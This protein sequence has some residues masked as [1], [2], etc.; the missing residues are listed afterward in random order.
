MMVSLVLSFAFLGTVTSKLEWAPQLETPY[1][2]F[3]NDFFNPDW[4]L[5]NDHE[6]VYRLSVPRNVYFGLICSGCF[7]PEYSSVELRMYSTRNSSYFIKKPPSGKYWEAGNNKCIMI[8]NIFYTLDS[9]DYLH[10]DLI[11]GSKKFSGVIELVISEFE[12][13]NGARGSL[14]RQQFDLTNQTVLDCKRESDQVT[15]RGT[16]MTVWWYENKELGIVPRSI[17]KSIRFLGGVPIAIGEKIGCSTFE[18][19]TDGVW[20]AYEKVYTFRG[21]RVMNKTVHTRTVHRRTDWVPFILVV[22]GIF[23]GFCCRFCEKAITLP[24]EK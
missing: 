18:M 10:C 2:I 22:I 16:N 24:D 7:G 20:R 1:V 23:V 11:S 3:M 9:S 17:S 15:G 8:Y 5:I 13:N 21:D 4:M 19:T 12:K 14:I 6:R